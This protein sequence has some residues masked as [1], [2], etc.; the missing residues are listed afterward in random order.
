MYRANIEKV[1]KYIE[2]HLKDDA[3]VLDNATLACVSGYSEYHFLRIFKKSVRLTPADYIRKR[4][5]SEIVQ[6]IGTSDRA[7]SDIAF[8]FGFNSKENF[9]RA[10]KSEHHI[11]PTEFKS[12][13]CSLCLYEPFSFDKEPICPSVAL[14]Y[15]NAFSLVAY[16]SSEDSPP[17]FWN[18]YNAEKRSLSLSGGKTVMDYG[19]MRWNA[20]TKKLDYYIGIRESEAMGDMLGTVRLEISKGL[21]AVFE[22][23]TASQHD[24]VYTIRRTWDWIYKVWL[25]K[26]GYRR[27]EG[28]E[29]E[30]YIESSKQYS[31]RIYIPL[32]KEQKNGTNNQ[33]I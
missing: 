7:I 31:E 20:D 16:K 30:C 27:A 21:Y 2:D 33:N 11:L 13:E 28:F 6:R 10:F 19:A 23:P 26:S 29:L 17:R 12:A 25:P 15:L 3:S 18:K 5:I 22:T 9:T 32:E 8:E 4:R 14:C 1:L 24:F